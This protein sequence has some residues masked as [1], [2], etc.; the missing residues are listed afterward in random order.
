MYVHCW[1]VLVILSSGQRQH[2]Q[3]V[4]ACFL[5]SAMYQQACLSEDHVC[6]LQKAVDVFL[7]CLLQVYK[8][9][10]QPNSHITSK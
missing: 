2:R 10:E 3:M 6:I 7:Y 8:D 5:Y 4:C 1:G 9:K